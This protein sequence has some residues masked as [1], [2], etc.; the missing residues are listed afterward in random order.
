[1]RC[2]A[3]DSMGA[4]CSVACRQAHRVA[5]NTMLRLARRETCSCG[6]PKTPKTATCLECA[7]AKRR[8]LADK[9]CPICSVVFRPSCSKTLLC[10][11]PE[12]ITARARQ[13]HDARREAARSS[14]RRLDG[15]RLRGKRRR[16]RLGARP[17]DGLWREVCERDGWVCWICQCAIDK[18]ATKHRDKGSVDHIVPVVLGGANNESNMRAAHVGCN[19]KRGTGRGGPWLKVEDG[20]EADV[21][22]SRPS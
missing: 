10:G 9:V 15:K 5:R 3:C 14:T 12:C 8:K 19:A 7:F 13:H 20:Q 21:S 16:Q 6:R 1:M 18:H 4:L 2:S 11:S 22:R 17:K